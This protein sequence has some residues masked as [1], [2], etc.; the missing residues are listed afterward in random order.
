MNKQICFRLI[1]FFF[2]ASTY[3]NG[4]AQFG[5]PGG[6]GS[7]GTWTFSGPTSANLYDVDWY[8]V[9]VTSGNHN[10]TF[11][12]VSG[13]TILSQSNTSV[14]VKWTTSGSNRSVSATA[15]I[16]GFL[17]V[18]TIYVYVNAVPPSTPSSPSVSANTCGNKT[19][20]RGTPPSGI[21]WYW[22]TASNG[23]STSNSSATYTK[24]S[25]GNVY[26]RA[27]DN[28]TGMWSSARS[29]SVT[30]NQ[31]PSTPSTP[32]VANNCGSTTLSRGAPPAGVI[33]YWQGTNSNGT[34][35]S[36][37]SSTYTISSAG[38]YYIR[39]R[40][41][42]GCWSSSRSVSA[43]VNTIP[44]TPSTP[45]NTQNC[46][47][48]VLT[49]GNPPSG[50]TWYWQGTNSSGTSTSNS[51][52]TYTTTS[53]GTYYIRARNNAT[54]CWG[55]SRAKSVTVNSVPSQPS[56]PSNTQNCGN[57]V[58]TRG[59]PPSGVT[60]YWQGTNS[61]GTS[62][63][64]ASSTYT[65]TS[66]G[67]YYIRARNNSTG[68]WGSSRA[69]SVTI[70]TVPSQPST[71]SHTQNCGSTI[72]TR[73]TPPSGVT[74][75]WQG[76]NSNGTSTS[77]SSSTYTASSSG[78]YYLRTRN[79]STGCWSPSRAKSV[80]INTI[81]SQPST[82]SNTQNCGNTVL[83]RSTPPSGI[84]WYWQGT[85]SNGTSTS[86]S[87]STYTATSNGTY[88]LRA[89]NNGT[90]CW[91][92]SR[93]KSITVNP[94]PTSYSVQ[95]GGSFCSGGSG[96]SVQ[97]SDTQT[98]VNYQ[99][100]RGSTNVGSLVSGTGSLINF[101]NQ[102]TAGTYTVIAT[103]AST[104]CSR[105]M[106]G[107]KTV[108]VN[109]LPAT[110]AVQG[111]GIFCEGGSGLPV[112]LSDSQTGVNYQL[113]RDGTNVGSA[114]SGTGAL[115]SFGNQSLVGNYTVI[116]TNTTTGCTSTMTG[117]ATIYTDPVT[118]GGTISSNVNSRCG[119]GSVNFTISGYTGTIKHWQY[120]YKNGSGSYTGWSIFESTDN[121]TSVNYNLQEWSGGVRT[122]Q[123][124]ARV[125]NG[126][127]SSAY[128]KKTVTVDPLPPVY[129]V[130]GGGSYCD[131][132]SGIAVGLS[133]SQTGFS[134]QLQKD[135]V[136]LGSPI[137]GTGTAISF[138]DQTST[139][140]YEV[141]ATNSNTGCTENM[142]GSAVV[143][144]DFL[145]AIYS[146]TGG[147][148]TCEGGSG[149]PIGLNDS[150]LGVE[151]QL[152]LDGSS[153]GNPVPGTGVAISFGDQTGEGT[154]MVHASNT[155]TGCTA[156]MQGSQTISLDAATVGGVIN[157]PGTQCGTGSANFTLTGHTGTVLR[158][159]RRSKIG[160]GNYSSWII[161]ANTYDVT[162]LDD[163]LS[164]SPL[165]IVTYQIQ[166]EVKNGLC[167]TEFPTKTIIVEPGASTPTIASAIYDFDGATVTRN[168]PLTGETWYWQTTAS[169]TSIAD[170]SDTHFIDTP[171][172]VYLRAQNSYNCWGDSYAISFDAAEPTNI[173]ATALSNESILL[174]WDQVTGNEGYRISR[175]SSQQ[176]AYTEIFTT[177]A[178]DMEYTDSGLS[179]GT[180]YY[181]RVQ[182]KLGT[183][184]STGL[185]IA[186]ATTT[187]EFH[188]NKEMSHQPVHNGNISA[189]RWKGFS[190]EE[191]LYTYHYDG[192]N[193]LNAAQYAAM[194]GSSYGKDKGYFT[195]PSI[196]YDLNGN[197]T[198]LVRQGINQSNYVDVIDELMYDYGAGGNQLQFVKDDRAE[199]GFSDG[200][201]VGNDYT[202]D[203]NGNM[204]QDLNK[205]IV[206]IQYN[207]LNLPRKVEFD[208]GDSIVYQYDAAG[209]KL[210]Q[211]VY[212]D[213]AQEKK[214]DYVGPFIYENDTLQLIQH[215]EGR[216]IPQYAGQPEALEGWDYQYHLKDHLG[217]V[218][219]T[220]S[221]T[222]EVYTQVATME[223][224][225]EA[226]N[227][228][229]WSQTSRSDPGNVG[230]SS[231]YVMRLNT[232]TA[233]DSTIVE[234]VVGLKTMFSV[235]K[236]D[237]IEL[238]TK[239]YYELPPA[240][241]GTFFLDDLFNML[242][243]GSTSGSTAGTEGNSIDVT[244]VDGTVL[245]AIQTDKDGD[246]DSSVPRAYLNYM[247]FDKDFLFLT[248]GYQQISSASHLQW[249]T[250]SLDNPIII[251]EE[252]YILVYVSNE[253]N[254]LSVVDFDDLTV[255]H[256]KTHVVQSD[257]YYPFGLTFSEYQRTASS[258]NRFKFN[259]GAER[260]DAFD[261][262]I[263]YTRYRNYNPALGRWWQADPKGENFYELTPY[264]YSF[265]NPARYND[266]NGDCPPG[267]PCDNPLANMQIR[268]NRASNLGPGNVRTNGT[269]QH[270][271]HDLAAPSGTN[272]SS[273]MSGTVV[274]A[275]E[276]GPL[277]NNVVVKT[278]IHPEAQADFTGPI[279]ENGPQ[280]DNIFV[281]YS[282]LDQIDPAIAAGE[283]VTMGQNIGTAGTTGN[284]EGFEGAEQHLHI[285][286]GTG[287]NA[288][289][290]NIDNSTSVSPNLVYNNVSFSSADP[291]A[292]QTN[293]SVV[294]TVTNGGQTARVYQPVGNT[295]GNGDGVLLDEV[296]VN[297]NN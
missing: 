36:N 285:Q 140:T 206:A 7:A 167:D 175:S 6:G 291:N 86:N 222:P 157:G 16:N 102:T 284:A 159:K 149:L 75:Y 230:N 294:K 259:D 128:P 205:G 113:R 158:W 105:T 249:E 137:S 202:Y 211:T 166:A 103:D 42:A 76:T 49:R 44:G 171:G 195:V 84:T 281:Q 208:S 173:A 79:N 271:G 10:S 120:R 116:A 170:Q 54:G 39:A 198:G 130:T 43:S 275:G 227:Y 67:T 135:G 278:N 47:N 1:T 82:P 196:A 243:T 244:N 61:S 124:R 2:C 197:I 133:G 250:V 147:G 4:L 118:V 65:A 153:I 223:D 191:R 183:Q 203:A 194:A 37:A 142:S 213:G 201:N 22:Q 139:G 177:N 169:G 115:L 18:K 155:S 283:T 163:I 231:S 59:T 154:Y 187:T 193:R 256:K 134:Y 165:G 282:H 233:G 15:A 160:S 125:Q 237:T 51:S 85:N 35:T 72:L 279:G 289:N 29:T 273:T 108:T 182:S 180:T 146:V 14:Q 162:S 95:G 255:T 296:Q 104:G 264:N 53:N 20:T 239:S 214:M 174:S 143:A 144:I 277:G 24:T 13:G 123:I 252:G 32:S 199:A 219:V 240:N 235:Q 229:I 245:G 112:E 141:I 48:T 200:A 221:T 210:S 94:L 89:R 286:V 136:D 265:N 87:S 101:G 254:A 226:A 62:T 83:T 30:V 66:N 242:L 127:C 93:A 272:V 185:Q 119:P 99:L 57:T 189:I 151:Y 270:S 236:G 297:N 63:S 234:G 126:V 232:N 225:A 293:T 190:E 3:L 64:N 21:T 251:E 181:Y 114:V 69:K 247:V 228:D 106:S 58:L 8:Y 209:I 31:Y 224:P 68:C 92:S 212:K 17:S 5:G 27:R 238:S 267:V 45:S 292:N 179:I 261:L 55:S 23:T 71:P 131:G 56:T 109:P 33:W 74:W 41:A 218:R 269:R 50:V 188:G 111:G 34:S 96:V 156:A 11:Y 217:N 216:I 91:S 186:S 73:G 107:S 164:E 184:L 287:M 150:Q 263:D 295:S 26:L 110:Y 253:T 220:F 268:Q 178:N 78:T 148:T 246:V 288:A 168:A 60:W 280:Q 161:L 38:T 248:A 19:L 262:N 88:Y 100:K 172:T 80:T 9:N 70:N 28:G 204:T 12:S 192:L 152:E 25:S 46:G 276:A 241:D 97:L 207:L 145:P 98:G 121:V 215:E 81:P 132:S 176:G 257:D 77:N 117:S 129:A 40:S 52:S 274:F 122:Y 266:P 90:G 290:V 138:G 258:V 260:E